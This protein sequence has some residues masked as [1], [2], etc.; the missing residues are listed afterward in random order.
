MTDY[1]R[2][3]DDI[4]NV[5]SNSSH[6]PQHVVAALNT[7][8]TE[9]VEEV[10]ERL[11]VCGDLLRRGQRTEAV[12]R[13]DVEPNLLE[14]VTTLDFQGLPLWVDLVAHYGLPQ[15]PQLNI[16]TAADLNEAYGPEQAME[17]L[18]RAHRTLALARAPLP[19]RIVVL[20]RIRE[21]DR[22]NVIW[23]EDLRAYE[24][25]RVNELRRDIELAER[26]GDLAGLAALQE[27][28][29][30]PEWISAPPKPVVEQAV[31]AY[32]RLRRSTARAE[33]AKL[34]DEL[35]QAFADFDLAR[36]RRLRSQ[37][38]AK[39]AIGL[40][41]D[42]D[43][44]REFV[45][46]AM[47]WL[48][49][50]DEREQTEKDYSKALTALEKALDKGADQEVLERRYHALCRFDEGVPEALQH[51]Y[52][53]R[54]H[55]LE[56][57]ATRRHR[58]V[59]L[60]IVL[61]IVTAGALIF[62]GIRRHLWNED[63]ERHAQS[64]AA[65][66]EAGKLTE[67][68][69]YLDQLEQQAPDMF[70]S[71]PVQEARGEWLAAVDGEN[72]RQAR[73][74]QHIR[75][76]R[77]HGVD[78]ATW[79]SLP[80]AEEAL[81]Q[82]EDVAI[83]DGERAEIDT[84]RHEIAATEREM[85]RRE[86]EQ[87]S[88]DFEPLK[89]RARAIVAV[90]RPDP[91]AIET[92]IGDMRSL[93][94]RQHVAAELKRD[95]TATIDQLEIIKSGELRR[96]AVEDALARL[97]ATVGDESA[98]Q[99]RLE[100]Y[101][102][103]YP[104]AT[105]RTSDFTRVATH[106]A[107]LWSSVEEWDDF[108]AA[109][110]GQ[111]LT[112]LRKEAVERFLGQLADLRRDHS[113]VPEPPNL[114]E[115]EAFLQAVS[116]RVDSSGESINRELFDAFNNPTVRDLMMVQTVSGKRYYFKEE[117]YGPIGGVYVFSYVF[118]LNLSTNDEHRIRLST[119][120]IDNRRL[121]TGFDWTAPQTR[122][123]ARASELLMALGTNG[124]EKTFLN[125][126]KELYDDNQMDAVLKYQLLRRF[127][128]VACRGS[129]CLE[130]GFQEHVNLLQNANF[131][132]RANWLNPDDAGGKEARSAASA[133]LATLGK[134]SAAQQKADEAWSRM[135]SLSFGP[136]RLWIGWLRRT[137]DSGWTCEAESGTVEK[138][139]GAL[140]VLDVSQNGSSAQFR[141]VGTLLN[142]SKSL[143]STSTDSGFVEGRAVFLSAEPAARRA[144]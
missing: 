94:N 83:D 120:V 107:L 99:Q 118:D 106:E 30:A 1:Q 63:V 110:S 60:A 108:V 143:T 127:L 35:T 129:Y 104:D 47:D 141:K 32:N 70:H 42:D 2:I 130:Q 11:R 7:Q 112:A 58:L 25:E 84:V 16:D 100:Y 37:W 125:I 82:A 74:K 59:A 41:D 12:R 33:L 122:F 113:G 95:V 78:N 18:M 46:P 29:R 3:I 26:S 79:E 137:L 75:T 101:A 22:S 98:F 53:Q 77:D 121:G 87:L 119:E 51:R 5:L 103:S 13:C 61:V 116:R 138:R 89:E 57:S 86:N 132:Q 65:F 54:I 93:R 38:N 17:R 90:E 126:L 48:A 19:Q 134:F 135:Q 34:A 43:E 67:A 27:E 40:S 124:W 15:P 76:A 80:L 9:A 52:A 91:G 23:E 6:H 49:A 68:G 140:V 111:N 133:A 131:D 114:E 81:K 39:A 123:R 36:G 20:R 139:S 102:R 62:W 28:A 71:A 14:T 96:K 144:D 64:V 4:Q 92:L 88:T 50:E 21:A 73:F 109:W 24:E 117:P 136:R 97:T 55:A 10:N 85:E 69:E 72:K 45:A 44:L 8:L 66:V 105:V 115:A 56:T 142:G 128:D 31:G